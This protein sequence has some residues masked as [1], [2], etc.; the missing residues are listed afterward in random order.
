MSI[1]MF[2]EIDDRLTKETL[3]KIFDRLGVKSIANEEYGFSGEFPESGMS[4]DVFQEGKANLGPQL[5]SEGGEAL[6]WNVSTRI[7][8]RY[9]NDNFD[10]CNADLKSFIVELA[11]DT[12]AHFLLSF[13][14]ETIYAIRDD[15][16]L[17]LLVEF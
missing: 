17:R 7:K 15:G 6:G 1:E 11:G 10:Q 14:F 3:V 9:L 8:F 16:G 5:I 13:Q 4:F 12:A 2:V